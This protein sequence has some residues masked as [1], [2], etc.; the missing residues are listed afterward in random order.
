MGGGHHSYE[1]QSVLNA[2]RD[3]SIT[4]GIMNITDV[5]AFR[6]ILGVAAIQTIMNITDFTVIQIIVDITVIKF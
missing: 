6:I 2:I 3:V 5:A 1:G 4:Q